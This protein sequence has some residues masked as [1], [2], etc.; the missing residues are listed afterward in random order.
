MYSPSRGRTP[1][2]TLPWPCAVIDVPYAAFENRTILDMITSG[3][4][5]R[6]GTAR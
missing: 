2:N 3:G 5:A 6:A 4:P 1:A